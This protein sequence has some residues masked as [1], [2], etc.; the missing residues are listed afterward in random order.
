MLE[1]C[2]YVRVALLYSLY[3]VPPAD[4]TGYV[5][6]KGCP[7]SICSLRTH[8]SHYLPG[9]D[10]KVTGI[11]VEAAICKAILSVS[12]LFTF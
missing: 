7:F 6:L 9:K 8:Y 11:S 2:F 3:F 10:K 5:F 4:C 1:H 12:E